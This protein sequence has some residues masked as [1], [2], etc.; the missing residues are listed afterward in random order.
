MRLLAAAPLLALTPLLAAAQMT[1]HPAAKSADPDKQVAGGLRVP[2]WA[3]HFDHAG[4]APSAVSF[5][6][7]G[8]GYRVTAGPAAIYYDSTKTAS[9]T[10]AV[11]ASFTQLK[12][13]MHPEAYGLFVGGQN[14]G[15]D[16]ASYLYFIVRG[17][18]RYAVKQRAGANSVRTL[19]DFAAAPALH[20]ADAAGRATNALRI[21]VG[22]DSVRFFANDRPVVALAT[23]ATGP[24]AGVAGFRVNHNLDVQVDNFAVTS[25]AGR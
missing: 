14:L 12:A 11:R 7:M 1:A 20:T 16:A 9:G 8:T 2:G 3:A 19:V 4:A 17:D 21:Q 25:G 22:P 24:V 6:P 10:Y 13:P 5:V 23:A 15:S 18:G